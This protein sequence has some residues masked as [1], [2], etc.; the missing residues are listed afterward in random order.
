VSR[1]VESSYI[2]EKIKE[3]SKRVD[4]LWKIVME[5][6]SELSIVKAMQ[7]DCRSEIVKLGYILSDLAEEIAIL[8]AYVK[9]QEE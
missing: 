7:E 6:S 9:I 8:K 4:E 3:L 5:L 1:V 2:V